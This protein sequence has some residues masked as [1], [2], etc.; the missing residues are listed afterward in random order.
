MAINS[1]YWTSF[2]FIFHSFVMYAC[3]H[4]A[5]AAFFPD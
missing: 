2:H 3:M 1:F 5:V 4:S